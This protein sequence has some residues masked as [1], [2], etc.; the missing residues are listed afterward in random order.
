MGLHTAAL[1]YFFAISS[2][3]SDVNLK[4]GICSASLMLTCC[5]SPSIKLVSMELYL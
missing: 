5:V 1:A 3:V 2:R 4:K